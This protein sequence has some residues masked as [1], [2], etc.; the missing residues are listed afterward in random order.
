VH[1]GQ[2]AAGLALP[3]RCPDGFDDDGITHGAPL[4]GTSVR[5]PNS[6]VGR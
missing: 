1:G 3:H 5:F 4:T 2:R 6:G